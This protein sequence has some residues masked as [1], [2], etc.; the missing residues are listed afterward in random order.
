M[1]GTPGTASTSTPPSTGASAD[2]PGADAPSERRLTEQGRERKEQLVAAAMELFA[3]RG[4][5]ATRISDI[6]AE[7]GVAF[8][9]A[10]SALGGGCR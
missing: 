7:A 10:A 9:G 5:A 4:Y 2:T 3:D 6:C 8:G 1:E